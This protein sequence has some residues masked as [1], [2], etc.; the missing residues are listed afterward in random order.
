MLFDK[1]LH[2]WLPSYVIRRLRK[3]FWRPRRPVHVLFCFVDHFEPMWKGA[4]RLTEAARVAEWVE[5]YPVVTRGHRDHDGV[6]PRHT[7]F[8]PEEEYRP[9]HLEALAGLCRQGFG[10]VEIHLHHDNDTGPALRK[11]LETFKTRLI[12]HGH[13]AKDRAT[14]ERRYGFIHGNWALD[15]SHP[16]GRWCGV[17][18]ELT[19]LRETGCYADFTLP[20]SPG[21]AQ[22]KKI[23]SIYYAMDDPARPNSHNTGLDVRVGGRESGDL[24]IIQGPLTLNW[25]RRKIENGEIEHHNPPTAERIRLWVEEAVHVRGRPEWVVVKVHTH[26][27]V[28]ANMDLL[29]GPRFEE[30]LSHLE[31]RYND[32]KDYILHY[33]TARELYNIIKAAEDG[34]MG[35]PGVHRGHRLT[36]DW[37]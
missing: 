9:E 11:S 23:N 34:K 6:P 18:D 20:S 15:N 21:E 36:S 25:R 13:L 27:T 32:G 37:M 2:I 19:I 29:L 17:N 8:Y 30:F 24:M 7:F 28:E 3:P 10:E 31:G 5:R 33:V 14:G 1:N 26:G 12:Q 4:D 35:D 22:T 16:Q